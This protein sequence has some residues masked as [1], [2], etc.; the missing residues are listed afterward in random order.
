MTDS[1]DAESR[2]VLVASFGNDWTFLKRNIEPAAMN[3]PT[4]MT[5]PNIG[6][7]DEAVLTISPPFAFRRQIFRSDY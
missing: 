1:A 7:I 4:T 5:A 3:R 2:E 6:E